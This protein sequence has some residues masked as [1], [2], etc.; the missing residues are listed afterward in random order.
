LAGVCAVWYFAEM[1]KVTLNQSN[2]PS[3]Q[4]YKP[5]YTGIMEQHT[6]S[7]AEKKNIK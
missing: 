6:I 4:I 7:L 3:K 2:M 1:T 5:V